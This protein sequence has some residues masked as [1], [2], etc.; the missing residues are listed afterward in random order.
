MRCMSLL[1]VKNRKS[2]MRANIVCFAPESRHH[3][4]PSACPFC[5]QT[6]TSPLHSIPVGAPQERQGDIDV[7]RFCGHGDRSEEHT[8]GLQ[9]HFKL[10][11]RPLLQKKLTWQ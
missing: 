9:S 10:V 6:P 5:A 7:G 2:S 1:W 11:F 8:A 4:M 3:A